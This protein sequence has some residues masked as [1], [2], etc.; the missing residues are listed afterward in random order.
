MP[1]SK[2]VQEEARKYER[3]FPNEL[4]AEWYRLYEIPLQKRGKPWHFK[5]L[6]IRHIYIPLA[7]RSGKVL[8]LL[9]ALKENKNCFSF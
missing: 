8:Q 6:T 4:Y 9:R 3:E 1:L 7:Q 2:F 5:H